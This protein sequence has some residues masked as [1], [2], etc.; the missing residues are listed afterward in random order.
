MFKSNQ[1]YIV[2]ARVD[3]FLCGVTAD[4]RDRHIDSCE[5]LA[6]AQLACEIYASSHRSFCDVNVTLLDA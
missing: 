1:Y 2:Q 6:S 4:G 5:S 3:L